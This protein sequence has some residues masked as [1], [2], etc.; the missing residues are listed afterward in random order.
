MGKFGANRGG[1]GFRRG[2]GGGNDRSERSESRGGS[3]RGGGFSRGGNRGG[4]RKNNNDNSM[5]LGDISV[6]EKV[7]EELGEEMVDNLRDANIG[8]YVKIY[9]PKGVDEITIR[10][11]D[12][13]NIRLCKGKHGGERTV[14]FITVSSSDE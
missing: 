14:G 5:K 3:S 1:G 11:G 2:N 13:L 7:V 12:Y 6:S 10:R 9:P 4:S 8:M